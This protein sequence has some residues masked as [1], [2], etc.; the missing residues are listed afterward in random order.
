MVDAP[1]SAS[2]TVAEVGSVSGD[3]PEPE[4]LQ[5]ADRDHALK[6]GARSWARPGFNEKLTK[7]Q[8]RWMRQFASS[9]LSGWETPAAT[10]ID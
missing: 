4:P 2:S 1:P 3:V 5:H 8:E 9:D 7:G 10:L 6:A